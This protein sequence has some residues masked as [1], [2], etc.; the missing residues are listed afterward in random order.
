MY[1]GRKSDFGTSVKLECCLVPQS[2]QVSRSKLPRLEIMEQLIGRPDVYQGTGG[3]AVLELKKAAQAF[4]I[5]VGD[6]SGSEAV[7]MISNQFALALRNPAGGE[8]MP[9]ALSDRDLA[10]LISST[11]GLTNTR[12]GNQLMVRIMIEL[13]KHKMRENSEAARFLQQR[14]SS[15]GL[16]EHMQAWAERNPSLTKQTRDRITG[17][18]GVQYGAQ[19][20]PATGPAA[21]KQFNG[22]L[23]EPGASEPPVSSGRASFASPG[24]GSA[25]PSIRGDADYQSLPS[26]S[27]YYAPDGS[28]RRKN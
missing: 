7:R 19:S 13:E 14:K 21:P 15:A 3:N 18:T 2:I 1:A 11:P 4:G 28:L 22:R 8:G 27:Q 10:F 24:I 26:G 20:G 23:N 9:G 16:A 25:I 6:L 17:L 12:Q 5:D